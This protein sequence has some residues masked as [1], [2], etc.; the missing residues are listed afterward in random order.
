MDNEIAQRYRNDLFSELAK[1]GKSLSSDRRLEVLDLLTQSE[2]SVE[3]IAK[4]LGMS[5]ANTSRHLQVLRE[6]N[7]VKREKMGNTV[8]YSL[9][10]DSV[11]KLVYL[12]E[13]VGQEQLA[14]MTQIQN[15]YDQE[16][17]VPQLS[18][19]NAVALYENSKTKVTI[20]DVRPQ[21]EFD[22]GHVEDAINIPIELLDTMVQSKLP[23]DT[24]IVYCRGRLC[25]YANMATKTLNEK[26]YQAYS[27]NASYHDWLEYIKQTA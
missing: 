27:L 8:V 4:E 22:A 20:L 11:K 2:K 9:A 23:D 24:I 21:S 25:A 10:S 26:G 18:L 7:L 5:V 16:V 13:S 15:D 3:T 19:A 1:V 12:L 6:G 14:N 17:N